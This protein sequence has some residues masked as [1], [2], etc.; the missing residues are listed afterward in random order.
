[1]L[2]LVPLLKVRVYVPRTCLEKVLLSIGKEGL[3]H[4]TDV[5]EDVPEEVAKGL[6]RPIDVSTRLYRISLLSSKID[7]LALTL[8]LS[9]SLIHI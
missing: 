5:K 3:L 6:L 1:M 8:R 4:L 2:T 7:K 9:L